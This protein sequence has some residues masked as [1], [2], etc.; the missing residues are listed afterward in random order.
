MLTG[1]VGADEEA[2]R[3]GGDAEVEARE[4]RRLPVVAEL[5][6]AH[7]YAAPPPPFLSSGHLPS[8]PVGDLSPSSPLRSGFR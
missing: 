8:P 1:S 7:L 2:A 6:G 3:A 4:E 5:Q